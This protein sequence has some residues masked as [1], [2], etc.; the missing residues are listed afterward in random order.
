MASRMSMTISGGAMFG[1]SGIGRLQKGGV[2][3]VQ[4]PK[5]GRLVPKNVPY[6]QDPKT[7]R[8]VPKRDSWAKGSTYEV[9]TPAGKLFVSRVGD[10]AQITVPPKTQPK[11]RRFSLE[12]EGMRI[13]GFSGSNVDVSMTGT[14]R[15]NGKEIDLLERIPSP[16]LKQIAQREWDTSDAGFVQHLE[17]L[18][19]GCQ[20]DH[21]RLFLLN[22]WSGNAELTKDQFSLVLENFSGDEKAQA[23][24]QIFGRTPDADAHTLVKAL[25]GDG[26]N[27]SAAA[28]AMIA[29]HRDELNDVK[30]ESLYT[31]IHHN[32]TSADKMHAHVAFLGADKVSRETKD[33]FWD[34]LFQESSS[35]EQLEALDVIFSHG[36]TRPFAERL[37]LLGAIKGSGARCDAAKILFKDHDWKVGELTEVMEWVSNSYK[38]NMLQALAPMKAHAE[39]VTSIALACTNSYRESVLKSMCSP[40]DLTFAQANEIV[41]ATSDPYKQSICKRLFSSTRKPGTRPVNAAEIRDLTDTVAKL[42]LRNVRKIVRE[43]YVRDDKNALPHKPSAPLLAQ[44]YDMHEPQRQLDIDEKEPPVYPLLGRALEKGPVLAPDY[45]PPPYDDEEKEPPPPFR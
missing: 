9:E 21:E 39:D 41:A 17:D 35:V 28:F 23:A 32:G 15:I 45:A 8:L 1:G 3:Y 16:E 11:I 7:G 29:E 18:R 40:G 31:P 4:D 5:T 43:S 44:T 42:Y 24:T 36:Y 14:L 33:E 30:K 13:K 26:K 12:E 2:P 27:I 20:D 37:N 34:G 25:V 19:K 10:R 22:Q 6:V 38:E